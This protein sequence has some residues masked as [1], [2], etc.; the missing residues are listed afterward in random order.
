MGQVQNDALYFYRQVLQKTG[1]D[2][3]DLEMQYLAAL[4]YPQGSIDDRWKAFSKANN[5]SVNSDLARDYVVSGPSIY[6]GNVATHCRLPTNTSSTN[7]T[8]TSRSHHIARDTITALKILLPNWYWSRAT[9]LTETAGGG[10]ITYTASVEY[11]AG[12]F[13]QI[14]FSGSSS[15]VAASNSDT[16]SDYATVYIPRGAS[17]WIRTFVSAATAIVFTDSNT[18][19]PQRDLANGEAYEYSAST[20]T[21]KTMGGTVNDNGAASAPILSPLAIV[22]QTRMPTVLIV[23]DSRDWGFTDL[24]TALGDLG[25]IARSVGPSY[26]YINAGC[27]GDTFSGLISAHTH[28]AALGSYVSHVIIGDAINALRAGGSGQNKSAATVL[29]ELQTVLGYFSGNRRFTTTC[30]GPNPSS[31]D[32]FATL[33]NQTVNSN[34]AQIIAY[35]DAIRAGVSN[36]LGYFEIADQVESARNSGKWYVTGG[37]FATT[38]EGL[39]S[40]TATYQRIQDSGCIIPAKL[41]RMGL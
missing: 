26:G 27:P 32:S 30:G 40:T 23:G 28:R 35:N 5:L 29:G 38:T 2:L 1:Q 6:L 22:A 34:S 31:T 9:T 39:H 16:L 11:P 12:T 41:H 19:F 10:N 33:A 15:V 21:D 14:K 25:D 20:T 3:P 7:K 18:G 24:G 4:G 17:F 13:T 37:A 36:S 8:A